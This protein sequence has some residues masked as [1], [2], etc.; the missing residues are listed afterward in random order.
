MRIVVDDRE[1][2]VNLEHYND[3]KA[4]WLRT[5]QMTEDSPRYTYLISKQID[6]EYVAQVEA[7]GE[8]HYQVVCEE[9]SKKYS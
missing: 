7:M 6:R 3:W 4:A 8:E 5:H 2:N 1:I 9:Y